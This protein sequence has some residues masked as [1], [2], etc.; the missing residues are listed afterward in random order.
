M[1]N[2]PGKVYIVRKC[3]QIQGVLAPSWVEF[4]TK[5]GACIRIP[6]GDTLVAI[7]LK[8]IQSSNKCIFAAFW[9]NKEVRL[10]T[11]KHKIDRWLVTLKTWEKLG[12]DKRLEDFIKNRSM[13]ST[14][15]LCGLKERIPKQIQG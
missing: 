1:I 12:H 3:S 9:E 2:K 4:T 7:S 15:T 8:K 13:Y 6:Y 14:W 10:L 5:N 11:S